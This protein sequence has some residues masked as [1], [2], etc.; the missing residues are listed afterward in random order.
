MI[1][2]LEIIK[3]SAGYL[4]ERGIESSRRTAEEVIADVLG[5]KRLDLYLQFDRP[6]TESELP[7]L[8]SAIV[9][10]AQH[11][12]VAYIAGRVAFAGIEL[13]V[14]RS[15]LIPRPETEILVE[16]I[17]QSIQEMALDGKVLW[18]MCCG[19]GCI[20]LALKTRFPLLTVI[21]SDM[22]SEALQTAQKNAHVEV[23]FKQGD[24]FAPFA[25]EGCDFF[26]CNPPY[27]TEGEFPE[28]APEV[29]DWEPK[30]ALVAGPT[31]LEYYARIARD[32]KAHLRQD[33]KAWLE[34]GSG[35]GPAVQALFAAQG[36]K[37]QITS[38]WAGHDRFCLVSG[39]NA[40]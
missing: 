31:G 10:R 39:R 13:N 21:L 33:G 22:S 2:L 24:L 3:R 27:I 5:M 30:K 40:L 25:G 11:E 38:D 4:A 7:A 34:I 20:G 6:L 23:Q 19:S 26:V 15:V 16:T 1:T 17:A 29:R 37:C 18:D 14:D 8:R 28:L 32:L 12:P 36:W 9:R 35:Q